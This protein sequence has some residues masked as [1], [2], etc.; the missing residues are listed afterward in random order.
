MSTLRVILPGNKG[1]PNAEFKFEWPWELGQPFGLK[2]IQ[3]K[4]SDPVRPLLHYT[5][6]FGHLSPKIVFNFV[7]H[8]I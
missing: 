2:L 8:F 6:S 3:E 5:H 7:F 4:P 1:M